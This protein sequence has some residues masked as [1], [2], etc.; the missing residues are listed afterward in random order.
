MGST[1]IAALMVWL[2]A[3]ASIVG[4]VV[5]PWKVPEAVWASLGAGATLGF[6]LISWPDALAAIRDGTD[7]Y[8]FLT[9]MLLLA[10]LARREGLFAWTAALATRSAGGSPRRLFLLI[11]TVGTVVTVFL[12]NDATAVVLTPAVYAATKDAGAPPLPY[13]FVCAFIANAASFV[14]PISNPANLVVYGAAMPPLGRW[15][16]QFAPASAAAILVT[17]AALRFT[18]RAR[19]GPPIALEVAVPPLGSGGRVAAAGIAATAVLL[20]ISS[21]F[22][23]P[24]GL[25]TFLAG[26]AAWFAILLLRRSPPWGALRDVSWSVLPLVAA[27]FVLVRAIETTG[28]LAPLMRQLG[29]PGAVVSPLRTAAAGTVAA[30]GTNLI[31][32]LPMGLIVAHL[33]RTAHASSR[34]AGALLIGVD[35]G[36]NLSVTG[37]LATILWL[38]ALRREGIEVSARRFLWLGAIVMPLALVAALGSF[39]LLS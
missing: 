8:L 34:L 15:L 3:G 1:P 28:A 31:N 39:L 21:A 26:A 29:A 25:P 13:L 10:E 19:L 33:L 17:Y 22:G 20:S 23:R 2:I 36:P 37:S 24:L 16:A 7:V 4:I 38:L 32:N 9:G 5:R 18:Q 14:L 30:F 6:S 11:Y 27:L 35:L 12:S